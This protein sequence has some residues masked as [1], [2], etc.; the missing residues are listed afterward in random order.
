[1]A[2]AMELMGAQDVSNYYPGWG[3]WGNADDT[4]IVVEK[5]KK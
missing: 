3:E 2:F 1:M 5:T 4:P